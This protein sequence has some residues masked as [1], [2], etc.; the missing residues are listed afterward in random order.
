MRAIWSMQFEGPLFSTGLIKQQ[1]WCAK[2][3]SMSIHTFSIA[4]WTYS[5]SQGAGAHLQRSLNEMRGAPWTGRQSIIRPH[6]DKQLLMFTLRDN[7]LVPINVTGMCLYSD[8]KLEYCENT[9]TCTWRACKLQEERP[10]SMS[11]YLQGTSCATVQ[12]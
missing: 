10:Q 9:F 8:G 2:S 4:T 6:K 7:L 3:S 1:L 11:F 12:P 5:G